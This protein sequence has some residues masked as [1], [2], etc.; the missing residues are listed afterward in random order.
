MQLE[1]NVL[2][3]NL[4]IDSEGESYLKETAKWAKFLSILGFIFS[5]LI[6]IAAFFIGTIYSTILKTTATGIAGVTGLVTSIYL[7]M[8]VVSFVFALYLYKFATKMQVALNNNDQDNL[9]FSFKNLKS[10]YRLAGILTLI[11]L[12]FF[13]LAI[14]IGLI[15]LM[16]LKH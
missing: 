13:V 11:Y 1:E 9:N 12:G 15:A 6:A 5:G 10:Y 2:Q 8:A 3:S 4:V 16:F 14:L 7:V